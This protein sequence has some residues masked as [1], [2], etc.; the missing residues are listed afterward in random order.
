[1][2]DSIFQALQDV[3]TSVPL[4]TQNFSK[5]RF[6]KWA[7]NIFRE[8]PATFLQMLQDLE[9]FAK[10]LKIQL[11]NLVD[12]KILKNAYLH[13]KIGADTAENE[14]MFAENLPKNWQLP[15]G[16]TTVYSRDAAG[17]METVG[18]GACTGPWAT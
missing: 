3:H 8:I 15:C 16:S 1:M 6:E 10:F 13:A 14:R 11:D 17:V 7:N 9:D 2:F 5:N 12:L 18:S 4:H